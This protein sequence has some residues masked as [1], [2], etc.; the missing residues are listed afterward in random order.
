M[1]NH[2]AIMDVGG[3]MGALL[4]AMHKSGITS[5]LYLFDLPEVLNLLAPKAHSFQT[6]TGDFFKFVPQVADAIILSRVLHD[7]NDWKVAI[8]LD[9]VYEALPNDGK[10]YILENLSDEIPEGLSLLS[11][12]MMLMCNS[13]ERTKG[14]YLNL[15][16][17]SGFEFESALKIN[18]LQTLL[19]ARKP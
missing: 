11:L 13:Y 9:K 10:V 8:I 15:L 12:N 17:E 19:V 14:E 5:K 3:G 6:I 7:W 1:H 2:Q 16:K 4:E 18:T